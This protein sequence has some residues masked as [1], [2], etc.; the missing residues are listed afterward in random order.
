MAAKYWVGGSAAWDAT[1]GSKWAASSGGGGGQAVPG[2]A[3]DVFFDAASGAVTVTISAGVTVSSLNCTGFTGN[4]NFG[5]SLFNTFNGTSGTMNFILGA[6]GTYTLNASLA[7]T[8]GTWNLGM[9]G[10]AMTG[11]LTKTTASTGANVSMSSAVRLLGGGGTTGQFAFNSGVFNTNGYALT[12]E[13]ILSTGTASRTFNLGTSIM[14]LTGI[15]SPWQ[16]SA[17]FAMT[18]AVGSEI[19]FTTPAGAVINAVGTNFGSA[20]VSGFTGAGNGFAISGANNTLNFK[21]TA[22]ATGNLRFQHGATTNFT[23]LEIKGSAGKIV[24][25]WSLSAGVTATISKTSGVVA[26]D[27]MTLQDNAAVGGASFYMGA[28]SSIVSNVSGWIAGD[29]PTP[30]AD[31]RAIIMA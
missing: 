27:Y 23:G 4:L 15:S 3:D 5:T 29:P 16:T 11:N 13:Q 22:N 21:L 24:T 31:T 12:A 7:G 8:T 1:A 18:S 25:V 28:N 14:T 26:C 10:N 30:P 20:L 9:N 2:S 19:R 17:T 6:A